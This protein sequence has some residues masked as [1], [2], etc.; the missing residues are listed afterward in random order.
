MTH[1]SLGVAFPPQA[2]H[3]RPFPHDNR[4]QN[5]PNLL[6]PANIPLSMGFEMRFLY[7][8]AHT[9]LDLLLGDSRADGSGLVYV[10]EDKRNSPLMAR[11]YLAN[12]LQ[13]SRLPSI[14][15]LGLLGTNLTALRQVHAGFA[16]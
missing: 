2:F 4:P 16:G 5:N 6:V 8:V 10:A 15:E 11:H 3:Y 7:S 13:K 9:A 12:Q 14:T 1:R